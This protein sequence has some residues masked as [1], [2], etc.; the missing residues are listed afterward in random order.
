MFMW[1]LAFFEND[2]FWQVF[3]LS[4]DFKREK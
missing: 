4:D 3:E 1:D 2:A